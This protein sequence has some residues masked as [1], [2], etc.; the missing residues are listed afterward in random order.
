MRLSGSDGVWALLYLAEFLRR[1]MQSVELKTKLGPSWAT[2]SAS[3]EELVR[4]TEMGLSLEMWRRWAVASF[5]SSPSSVGGNLSIFWSL[6]MEAR[7]S[8]FKEVEGCHPISKYGTLLIHWS[9][10]WFR[11]WYRRSTTCPL[12]E[13]LYNQAGQHQRG[14]Q[15][16]DMRVHDDDEMTRCGLIHRL[17]A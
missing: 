11:W 17:H 6:L 3:I 15:I 5:A 16:T 2:E 1:C 7:L 10:Q 14:R 9:R 8:S 13:S 4:G 12:V